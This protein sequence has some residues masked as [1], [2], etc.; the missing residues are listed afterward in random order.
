MSENNSEYE[1]MSEVESF[2]KAIFTPPQSRTG[3]QERN[4][5]EA[6]TFC[7]CYR[8]TDRQ[9]DRPTDKASSRVACPRLKRKLKDEG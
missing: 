8:P 3:G 4:S 9:T 7:F 5:E 2:S 1:K 6:L